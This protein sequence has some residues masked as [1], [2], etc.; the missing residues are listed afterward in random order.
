MINKLLDFFIKILGYFFKDIHK[1]EV[2]K[3]RIRTAATIIL[4]LMV[5]FVTVGC[6][7]GIIKLDRILFTSRQIDKPVFDFADPLFY[8]DS[9]GKRY[10]FSA[11]FFNY[12]KGAV[13][14]LKYRIIQINRN[15]RPTITLQRFFN[16]TDKVP[17]FV[18]YGV[19]CKI[20]DTDLNHSIGDLRYIAFEV[21]Y[22]DSNR[23]KQGVIH[24]I[25]KVDTLF[26][27]KM[28]PQITNSEFDSIDSLLVAVSFWRKT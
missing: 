28:P 11:N 9:V 27:N 12:G 5:C 15:L 23:I 19:E 24:K 1:D 14:D 17:P 13:Y 21:V 25:F 16:K 26:L 8:R 2:M 4:I 10:R 6:I 20:E 7:A 22:S 18:G 3:P